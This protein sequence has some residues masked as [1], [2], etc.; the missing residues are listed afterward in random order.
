MSEIVR[1][2]VHKLFQCYED[3]DARHQVLGLQRDESRRPRR[4]HMASYEEAT[5]SKSGRSTSA[6]PAVDSP[7]IFQSALVL[8]PC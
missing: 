8:A 6:M 1:G 5:A 4:G 3:D 2:A 7:N